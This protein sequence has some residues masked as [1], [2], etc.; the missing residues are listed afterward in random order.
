MSCTPARTRWIPV[1]ALALSGCYP[2][3]RQYLVNGTPAVIDVRA[4]ES[5]I[6]LFDRD[7]TVKFA[8]IR[9]VGDTIYGW[10]PHDDR[11]PGDSVAVALRRVI[12][13]EQNWMSIPQTV[14]GILAGVMLVDTA[15]LLAAFVALQADHS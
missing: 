5:A 15:G 12:A 2:T 9:L 10:A 7:S 3:V 11:A 13:I 4:G 14:G 6:V 1:A 8:R